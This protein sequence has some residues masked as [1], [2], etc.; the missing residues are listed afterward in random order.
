M[1][2]KEMN[3]NLERAKLM[4]QQQGQGREESGM[5]EAWSRIRT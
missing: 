1:L 3:R 4:I 5:I 2:G